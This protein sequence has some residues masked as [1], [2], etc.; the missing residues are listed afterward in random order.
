MNNNIRNT[1]VWATVSFM[2]KGCIVAASEVFIFTT[3]LYQ[4]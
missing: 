2:A 3:Q 1:E 4:Y